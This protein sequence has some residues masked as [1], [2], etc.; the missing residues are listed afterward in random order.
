[1]FNIRNRQVS[2]NHQVYAKG[3][4]GAE[5]SDDSESRVNSQNL[6]APSGARRLTLK[7]IKTKALA[8]SL[9]KYMGES[10]KDMRPMV[11]EVRS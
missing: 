10:D 3:R 11:R 5:A 6:L 8:T 9:P 1:M 4:Q 7:D 2:R